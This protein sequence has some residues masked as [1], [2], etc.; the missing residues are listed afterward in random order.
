VCRPRRDRPQPRMDER[1][2]FDVS[3]T[4]TLQLKH[5]DLRRSWTACCRAAAERPQLTLGTNRRSPSPSR[6][7]LDRWSRPINLA[8]RSPGWRW[9][10]LTSLG[11]RRRGDAVGVGLPPGQVQWPR[12]AHAWP[13]L[14]KRPRAS[15]LPSSLPTASGRR[16]SWFRAIWRVRGLGSGRSHSF[17]GP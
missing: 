17:S 4:R 3:F 5:A 13:R 14:Q 12:R 7:D 15:R 16:R 10:P 2:P 1:A 11:V 8:T 9:A 6:S